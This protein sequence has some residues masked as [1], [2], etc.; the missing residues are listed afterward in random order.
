[1]EYSRVQLN[2]LSDEILMIILKKLSNVQVLYSLIGVNKR[3][4]KIVYDSIFTNC[5]TLMVS[6]L[7]HCIFPLSEPILDRFCLQILPKIHN[8]IE[9]LDLEAFSMERIL[10]ATNYPNLYGFS[11][12]NIQQEIAMHLFNDE[13]PFTRT[14]KNQ[15]LSLAISINANEEQSSRK[16][17]NAR[18]FM[19]II[20][21]FSY[22]RF[23]NFCPSLNWCQELS[24]DNSFPFVF[25]STLLKLY[26]CLHHFTDCLY[27]LDGRFNQLRILYV[28]INIISSSN[29]IINNQLKLPNLRSFSLY[30][31]RK[32]GAYDELIVPLL[33]R[34]SDL[35]ELDLCLIVSRKK[36]FIDGND[37]KTNIINNMTLLNKFTFNIRSLSRF[38]NQ[39]N[40][41]SNK[42]IR[43]TFDGFK[44]NQIISC[45]DYFQK[46]NYGQCHMYSYPYKLK[47]YDNITNNFP[48]GIFKC[49]RTIS[50]FDERPFEHEFFLQISQSFPLIEKLTLINKKP[51][52]NKFN[53]QSKDDNRPSLIV[54]QYSHLFELNLIKTHED[55]LE[56]FLLD[57]KMCLPNSIFLH[58]NYQLLKEVT[59]N[60]TRNSTRNN[61]AKIRVIFLYNTLGFPEHLKDYFPHAKICSL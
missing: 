12:Y 30:C 9:W 49:V 6:F 2:D 32:T 44:D 58:I 55:Y 61:C 19:R 33:H 45:I 26:V 53:E 28:T 51:Q 50:L 34:M 57:T 29:L 20:N 42:D 37:L 36:I 4:N 41:P 38:Y 21:T 18:I 25:S 8:K 3:L 43:H 23:L 22:L 60:F 27:L 17:I 52:I 40:F 5:L 54:I 59:H 39:I 46:R 47:Y 14:F 11:L 56:Q 48:G 1:M 35:E 15:I 16:D 31:H 24:F 10:R 13:C 7:N